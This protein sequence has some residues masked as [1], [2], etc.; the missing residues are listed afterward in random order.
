MEDGASAYRSTVDLTRDIIS[1]EY[2]PAGLTVDGVLYSYLFSYANSV[3]DVGRDHLEG[4]AGS[5]VLAGG[6]RG[7]ELLGGSEGDLLFGGRG[8]DYLD[9]G[10]GNDLMFASHSIERQHLTEFA[11]VGTGQTVVASS[12][13]GGV[14]VW[15]LLSTQVGTDLRYSVEGLNVIDT[16]N[17]INRPLG[18]DLSNYVDASTSIYGNGGD[19]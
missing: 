6:N 12:I 1:Y 15:R 9:G 14:P 7:D 2:N 18:V 3:Q 16:T 4:N 5:D 11:E 8:A 17:E 19:M 10:S 13:V